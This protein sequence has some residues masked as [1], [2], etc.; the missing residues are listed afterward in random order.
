MTF[1][2]GRFPGSWIYCLAISL[3][4]LEIGKLHSLKDEYIETVYSKVLRKKTSNHI[5]TGEVI[6]RHSPKA[7]DRPQVCLINTEG[8]IDRL[9]QVPFNLHC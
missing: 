3:S 1:N 6:T 4:Y 7:S 8:M 2:E 5:E 9:S